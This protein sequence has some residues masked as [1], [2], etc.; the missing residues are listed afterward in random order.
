MIKVLEY[1]LY[2]YIV[3]AIYLFSYLSITLWNRNK[4]KWDNE[5]K[6]IFI[7]L[8]ISYIP[9]LPIDICYRYYKKLFD[10]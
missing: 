6:A 4:Y 3:V 7:V 10:K 2:G 9:I 1:L 5:D 8:M